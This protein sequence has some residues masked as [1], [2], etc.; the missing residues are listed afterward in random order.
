M[1]G[2][3]ACSTRA[4]RNTLY[5]QTS[6]VVRTNW[7]ADHAEGILRRGTEAELCAVAKK[8]WAKVHGT[9]GAKR[10]DV[11]YVV[12][13]D[14]I[15]GVIEHL[16]I[17]FW[18]V[19]ALAAAAETGRVGSRVEDAHVTILAVEGLETLKDGLA[20]MHHV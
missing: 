8:E 4:R 19:Q 16:W 3:Y 12:T 5:L 10:R 6:F 11:V 14:A 9:A 13:D 15:D 1:G 17:Y 20:V 2:T 18:H 7:R